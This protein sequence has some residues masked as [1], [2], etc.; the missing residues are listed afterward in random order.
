M[1]VPLLI[2]NNVFYGVN[3][4]DCELRTPFCA[5]YQN[6]PVWGSFNVVCGDYTVTLTSDKGNVTGDGFYYS[7]TN[8]TV[9][10]TPPANQNYEFV[11]WTYSDGTIASS[12][13]LYTFAVTQDI[14]LKANFAPVLYN[15]SYDLDD[16]TDPGNPGTY[17]VED[18]TIELAAP[19]R[20]GYYFAGWT[21]DD[22]IIIKGSTGDKTFTANWTT[23]SSF[24]ITYYLNGGTVSG[25]PDTYAA[26]DATIILE[27]PD[28]NGYTFK[29]WLPN[30]T[31]PEGSYGDKY[32]TA[33]WSDAI[34]Y[35]IE[36][37][38]GNRG[39]NN[40]GNPDATL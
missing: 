23:S 2:D 33:Q 26:G 39:V 3:K 24:T 16:G 11:N 7:G 25:N 22:G 35:S 40:A 32:F 18:A 10:A 29:G 30:N 21:P 17:T 6:A 37:V 38:L 14:T 8:A 15:I 13:N 19:T 31:I 1:T 27:N 12:D 36:Y 5:D 4:Q 28:R 9:S 20:Q 34:S